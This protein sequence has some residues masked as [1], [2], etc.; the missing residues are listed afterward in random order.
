MK[1]YIMNE[2]KEVNFEP[3]D[4]TTMTLWKSRIGIEGKIVRERLSNGCM[5]Y[6]LTRKTPRASR[7]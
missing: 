3:Q 5:L 2:M 6:R 1:R 4:A 7:A